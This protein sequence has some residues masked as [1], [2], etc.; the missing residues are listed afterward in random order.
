MAARRRKPP[1]RWSKPAAEAAVVMI[2][3]ALAFAAGAAGFVIGR[4]T[5]DDDEPAAAET[6]ETE[7]QATE[8]QA[9]E[10]AETETETETATETETETEGG[11]VDGEAV[12]ASAGCGSCHQFEPAGSTGTIGPP[13]DGIDLSKDEIAAQVRNGGGGMPAFGDRLSDDE[14]DAVAD[15]VEN[16]G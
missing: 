9:T 1:S 13:L 4:E 12:F 6:A 16:A 10:T 5:A 11:E 3:L 8:T 2:A 15:Y 14:I 7:T